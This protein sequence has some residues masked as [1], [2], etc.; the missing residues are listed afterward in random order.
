MV[1]FDNSPLIYELRSGLEGD[2]YV[3]I[4]ESYKIIDGRILLSELPAESRRVQIEGYSE[5]LNI[6]QGLNSNQFFVN[7]LSGHVFFNPSEEGKTVQVHFYGRGL[8]YIPDTRIYTAQENGEVTQLL[9]D[10]TQGVKNFRLVGDYDDS[11]TYEKF[12]LVTYEGS[13]YICLEQTQGNNP[14]DKKYWS[15]V[16]GFNWKNV[17]DSETDYNSG[18]VV[19]NSEKTILYQAVKSSK[20]QSLNDPT[21]WR[22]IINV[23]GVVQQILLAE[24]HR[25]LA[26][27][28]R[29]SNEQDRISNE[30]TRISAEDERTLAESQRASAE[31]V[32]EQNETIR[33]DNEDNRQQSEQNRESAESIRENNEQSRINQESVRESNEA[34][35]QT[36][37][38]D[39]VSAENIREENESERITNENA[40]Q[41]NEAVRDS[42]E[43]DRISAEHA[44]QNNESIRQSQEAQR[45]ADTATAIANT[46]AATNNAQN[47]VDTSVH[48]GEYNSSTQYVKNNH[49]RYNG[50]TWRCLQDCQGVTPVEGQFWTL[51]ALRGQDGAGSVSSVNNK[52]PDAQGNVQLTYEDVGAETPEGA[53]S[54]ADLAEQNAKN[55]S[56]PRDGSI[57]IPIGNRFQIVHNKDLDSIDF[58]VLT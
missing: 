3:E 1:R 18:D 44:R 10:F 8:V 41:N 20:G 16:S 19:V 2:E 42:N 49:V 53:Q 48:L 40:R 17:Y 30:N 11:I 9:S 50:S 36:Q 43:A 37:E 6:A 34:T 24:S 51:V 55:A 35:R 57:P 29:E 47:L 33:I 21:Y 27:S 28:V 26:E 7:Y 54:K 56:I 38:Q 22:E 4:T 32:R 13:L 12:N 14:H 58:E 23:D 31:S 52:S 39:R 46:V 45:Q 15:L 5:V 25:E